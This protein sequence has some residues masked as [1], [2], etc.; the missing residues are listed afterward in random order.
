MRSA[1]WPPTSIRRS[2]ISAANSVWPLVK[3]SAI[4]RVRSISVWLIWR[5]RWSSA[6]AMRWALLSSASETSSIL[7]RMPSPNSD[8]LAGERGLHVLRLLGEGGDERRAALA[9]QL[10]DAREALVE[11]LAELAGCGRR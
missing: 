7:T 5:E 6:S 11:D 4:S 9:D 8:E 2:S 3:V 10:G 1:S